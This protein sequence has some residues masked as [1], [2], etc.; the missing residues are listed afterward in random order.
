M[1]R[2]KIELYEPIGLITIVIVLF[3]KFT[4]DNAW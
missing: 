4:I 3:S 1:H 2:I